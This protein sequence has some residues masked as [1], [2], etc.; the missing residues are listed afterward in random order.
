MPVGTVI[1][2][3][4][5]SYTLLL[6]G[7]RELQARLRGRL[8]QTAAGADKLVIGDRVQADEAAD[9]SVTIESVLPR[10]STMFP[11]ARRPRHFMALSQDFSGRLPGSPHNVAQAAWL[12]CP[13]EAAA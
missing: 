2:V 5:G 9:G 6:E 8:K 12:R 1:G 7:G 4:G 3:E 10:R 11:L 13:G